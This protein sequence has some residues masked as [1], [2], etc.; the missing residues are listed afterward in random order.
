MDEYALENKE[1]ALEIAFNDS[2]LNEFMYGEDTKSEAI[3]ECSKI[4]A[5]FGKAENRLVL[6]DADKLE[7]LY[8]TL[9]EPSGKKEQE[10]LRKVVEAIDKKIEFCTK[11][12]LDGWA[13]QYDAMVSLVN[14]RM[15]DDI[16]G[17]KPETY[18]DALGKINSAAQEYDAEHGLS[19]MSKDI[20]NTMETNLNKMSLWQPDVTNLNRLP[21]NKVVEIN[22]SQLDNFVSQKLVN[23]D[24][25][26]F[27]DLRSAM[28]SAKKHKRG[29]VFALTI[30]KAEESAKKQ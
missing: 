15:R 21:E 20:I 14:K 9:K 23:T 26:K 11:I 13:N 2:V 19:D 18:I 7:I 4:E 16:E 10:A 8:N 1:I 30:K 5:V 17:L 28:L 27:Y 6:L 24:D 12:D 22:E 3:S 25:I 29:D